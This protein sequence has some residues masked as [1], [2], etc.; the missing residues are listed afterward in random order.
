MRTARAKGRRLTKA[1]STANLTQTA[2]QDESFLQ[3][4]G[5]PSPLAGSLSLR[6]CL[7]PVVPLKYRNLS[8]SLSLPPSFPP[9]L[10][11][12]VSHSLLPDLLLCSRTESMCVCAVGS[13]CGRASFSRPPLWHGIF[14]RRTQPHRSDLARDFYSKNPTSNGSRPSD[15][16][17]LYRKRQPRKKRPQPLLF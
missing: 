14:I 9:S 2:R 10:P 15:L 17:G 7:C 11:L 13:R 8:S 16:I 5:V 4:D 1:A 3:V 6:G 12:I